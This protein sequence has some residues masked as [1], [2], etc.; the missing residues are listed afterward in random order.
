[1][2]KYLIIMSDL[3]FSATFVKLVLNKLVISLRGD[4]GND[5]WS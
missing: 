4:L 3:S 1:M 2:S 5:P